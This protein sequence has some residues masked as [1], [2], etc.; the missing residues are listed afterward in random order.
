MEPDHPENAAVRHRQRNFRLCVGNGAVVQMGDAFFAVNTVMA[1]LVYQLTGSALYV[2][3]Y[4]SVASI[5]WFWPQLIVGGLTEHLE[6]KMPIYSSMIKVRLGS[7]L[8]MVVLL[9][10]WN[11]GP[12]A[13]FGL[14][15]ALL[16]VYTSA[17]G[18]TAVPFLD[19]IGKAIPRE[20]IAMLF[21]YRSLFGGAL[22]FLAGS[23][24][25]Y[26]LSA[27]SGIPYPQNYAFLIAV[28]AAACGVGY[29]LFVLVREPI[30]PVPHRRVPFVEFL[31]RGPQ[32]FRKDEDYRRFFLFKYFWAFGAMTQSLFVPYAVS[33]FN[34]P[35]TFTGWYTAVVTLA[36]GL[37]GLLW[38]WVAG[39][40]GEVVVL[41]ASSGL[42]IVPPIMALLLG[43]ANLA[44]G[45]VGAARPGHVWL[46]LL[47]MFGC[48][49]VAASGMNIAALAYLLAL[50]PP[51]HRPTYVAFHN[52][53]AVPLLCTPVL[54]GVLVEH[55]SYALAFAVSAVASAVALVWAFFLRSGPATTRPGLGVIEEV[56]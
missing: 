25:A 27:R 10:V 23:I 26:V 13:L 48:A 31:K 14:L 54:A 2:G 28:G 42:L 39:R 18:V 38:G 45:S 29:F 4:S 32:I 41:R 55:F 15:L 24:V 33:Q 5:G 51:Q 53:L 49:A 36:A 3:L 52:T 7:L 11:G 16:A 17:G 8:A 22:G 35:P 44:A 20:Q 21:A 12:R 43:A 19:I 1:G 9:L 56:S 40:V 37:S 6:R 46:L 50:S 47:V 34:T 30:G